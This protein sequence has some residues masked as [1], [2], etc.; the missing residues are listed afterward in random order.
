MVLAESNLKKKK[1]K[2]CESFSDLQGSRCRHTNMVDRSQMTIA[3]LKARLNLRTLVGTRSSSKP[4][5]SDLHR[6]P[7]FGQVEKEK[8]VK[9]Y[10]SAT[11]R[12]CLLTHFTMNAEPPGEHLCM[13]KT[14]GIIHIRAACGKEEE[15]YHTSWND[16]ERFVNAFVSPAGKMIIEIVK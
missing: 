15:Y 8:K 13:R 10:S 2:S 3:L 4:S 6:L 9:R 12:D 7:A 14:D 16:Y 1:K 11:V 5:R